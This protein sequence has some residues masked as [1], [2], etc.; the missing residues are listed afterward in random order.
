MED[1]FNEERYHIIYINDYT[2]IVKKGEQNYKYIVEDNTKEKGKIH[3]L[4]WEEYKNG[5]GRLD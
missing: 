3:D 4:G 2:R 1:R 5:S